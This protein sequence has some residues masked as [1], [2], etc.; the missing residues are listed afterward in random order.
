MPVYTITMEC[1]EGIQEIAIL[2]HDKKLTKKELSDYIND[3][4]KKI[5]E[6]ALEEKNQTVFRPYNTE[7]PYKSISTL[8]IE[9]LKKSGFKDLEIESTIK[10]GYYESACEN[11]PKELRKSIKNYNKTIKKEYENKKYKK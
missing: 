2:E 10:L 8:I 11:L 1:E 6:K 9:E 5:L 3:A 4:T 7:P